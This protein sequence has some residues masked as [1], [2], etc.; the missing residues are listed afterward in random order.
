MLAFGNASDEST[1]GS[2]PDPG[3]SP[4]T[5]S[6]EPEKQNGHNERWLSWL[7]AEIEKLGLTVTPSVANFL[8]IHFP[9]D[10]ERGAAACDDYLKSRAI[11]L[12]RVAAYVLPDCLRLTVGTEAENR[13][14]IAALSAFAGKA[15]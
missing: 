7:A 8:L 14:V 12:R 3:R 4:R 15:P 2:R 5:S 1:S 6:N 13:A 11:I 10:A 9:P